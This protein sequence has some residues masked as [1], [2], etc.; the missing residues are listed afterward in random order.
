MSFSDIE[1]K[2]SGDLVSRLTNDAA[3]IQDFFQN[4]FSNFFYQPIA[5]LATFGYM[6]TLNL[7]LLL[8]AVAILPITF[9]GTN[10]LSRPMGNWVKKRQE[11]F[12]RI[13]AIVQDTIGGI[14]MQKAFNLNQVLYDKFKV[15]VHQ[16]R[17]NDLKYQKRVAILSTFYLIIM[18]VPVLVTA[19]YGG[20]L[21]I[22]GQMTPGS[23]FAFLYLLHFLVEPLAPFSELIPQ[24]RA[25]TAA[26]GR[27]IEVLQHPTERT[28]GQSFALDPTQPVI[29]YAEVS[30]AYYGHSDVLNEMNFSIPH[31]KT[32]ALVGPSGSGKSTVFKLLC[33]FYEPHEGSVKLNG[34]EL[35]QWNLEAVRRQL[36]LVSQDTYLFPATVA[37]N[38]A[39]GRPGATR[40]EIIKAARAANAH[41]FIMNLPNDYDSL[42]GERGNRL[43][44]GQRQRLGI[45][46][47]ILKNAPVLLLDEPTSALD[48]QSE[49]LV[50]EALDRMMSGR[51]VLVIAHRMST[52]KQ[53]DEILVLDHGRIVE[54][55]PHQALIEKDGLYKQLYLKQFQNGDANVEKIIG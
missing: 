33:G 34:R 29:E 3:V 25:A 38:I 7:K 2:H 12:G 48:V 6:A 35:S 54:Q 17:D 36:S 24:L 32:V 15:A 28:D 52:I 42:V 5:F 40:D 50:Q 49:A 23:L 44:G 10:F 26:A 55:G 16:V 31:C 45:A 30:F 51:T 39:Y 13:N 47:A 14:T 27:I 53:A 22:N 4:N 1:A 20:Y 19:A 43:S 9:F 46:R 18:H 8:V 11:G 41:D 21:A 37:E